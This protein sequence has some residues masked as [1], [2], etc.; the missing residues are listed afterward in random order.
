[1]NPH[2]WDSCPCQSHQRLCVLSLLSTSWGYNKKLAPNHTGTLILFFLF[3]CLF[4]IE[5]TA[6]GGSQAGGWI[7]S[8]AVSYAI[9]TATPDL[10]CVCERHHSSKQCQILNPLSGAKDRTCILMDTSWVHCHWA[11][12]RT[13]CVSFPKE[14]P[15]TLDQHFSWEEGPWLYAVELFLCLLT[16]S[17]LFM[18]SVFFE[19]PS[20]A[21]PRMIC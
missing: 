9:A 12:M 19:F 5:P 4:K 13:L 3:F 15:S 16:C 20:C 11:T 6:N 10:S 8:V 2:Y 18:H 7:R 21:S 17:L 1:M 14:P